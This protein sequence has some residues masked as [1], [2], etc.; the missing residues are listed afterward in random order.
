M[1]QFTKEVIFKDMLGNVTHHFNI[2]DKLKFLN[3]T[4][5]YFITGVGGI[6]FDE[7]I[8]L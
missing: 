7:A 4:S 5:T 6:Y 2:G 3:K 1:I 8:E